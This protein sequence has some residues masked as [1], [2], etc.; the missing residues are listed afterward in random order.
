MSLAYKTDRHVIWEKF[1][2][3]LTKKLLFY[4]SE[5]IEYARGAAI[6]ILI[7]FHY[8]RMCTMSVSNCAC[9]S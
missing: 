8:K 6:N 5:G 1:K 9:R 4:R 2:A 7:Q 3:Q